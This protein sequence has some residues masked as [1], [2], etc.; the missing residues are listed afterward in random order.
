[1]AI[2]FTTSIRNTKGE[3]MFAPIG[4][5]SVNELPGFDQ[6]KVEDLKI[7][8]EFGAEPLIKRTAVD[9]RTYTYLHG[10]DGLKQK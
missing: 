9:P 1:M 5:E 4:A 3:R 6:I 2:S 8:T 10:R 7:G